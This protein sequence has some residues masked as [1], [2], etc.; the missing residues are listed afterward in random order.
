MYGIPFESANKKVDIATEP[1]K[2]EYGNVN[3][4]SYGDILDEMKN[5]VQLYADSMS[6]NA[7]DFAEQLEDR[8]I[9]EYNKSKGDGDF[10][11][12]FFDNFTGDDE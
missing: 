6:D 10:L 9:E 11:D 7:V 8:I 1:T 12:S 5:D 2:D 3:I 4:F